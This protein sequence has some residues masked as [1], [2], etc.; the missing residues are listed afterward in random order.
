MSKK[1]HDMFAQIAGTYDRTNSVLSLGIHHLWRNRLI[2]M[3]ETKPGDAILDCATGTGDVAI[4]FY[5]KN[6][7]QGRIVGTDFCAP[8]LELAE[9]K[10]K[11][12]YPE[13]E[14]KIED[15]QDLSFP[16]NTFDIAT[17][18]FGIRNVDNTEDCLKSMAR[19][20]KPG[21]KVLILEFGQPHWP[22]KPFFNLY[23][24]YILPFVGGIISGDR[25]AYKY[26]NTSSAQ[27]PTGKKFIE[28]MEKTQAFSEVYF[29][30][31]TSGV[32]YIYVG[33]V[34]G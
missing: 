3:S 31:L 13:I 28:L 29:K 14:W 11:S 4:T 19:V 33:K 25:K 2:K 17:I 5:K 16:D 12:N 34:A 32:C 24:G 10:S 1:I 26:L 18:S 8:M 7:G 20:V 23:S 15:A 27:F 22:I 6:K 9:K 21:G 30:S